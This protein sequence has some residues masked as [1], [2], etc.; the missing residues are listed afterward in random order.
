M[1]SEKFNILSQFTQQE[2]DRVGGGIRVQVFII[3]KSLSAYVKC[4]LKQR[5]LMSHGAWDSSALTWVSPIPNIAF[6]GSGKGVGPGSTGTAEELLVPAA[7]R[8]QRGQQVL[9][10]RRTWGE[11]EKEP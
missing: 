9:P 8:A 7:P 3:L 10:V 11:P 4:V 2:N 5:L 1:R 6:P